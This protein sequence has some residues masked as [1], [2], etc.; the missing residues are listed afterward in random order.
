MQKMKLD[1]AEKLLNGGYAFGNRYLSCHDGLLVVENDLDDYPYT[2][3]YCATQL[4]DGRL[5]VDAQGYVVFKSVKPVIDE[6][7]RFSFS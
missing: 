7:T 4:V 5:E 2:T 1:Y 3:S 6:N